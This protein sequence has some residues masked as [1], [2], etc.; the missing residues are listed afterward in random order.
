MRA[1]HCSTE[2]PGRVDLGAPT[3]DRMSHGAGYLA[4]FPLGHSHLGIPTWPTYDRM[5][6]ETGTLQPCGGRCRTLRCRRPIHSARECARNRESLPLVARNNA[7][8]QAYHHGGRKCPRGPW[9]A[10]WVCRLRVHKPQ[11]RSRR[12]PPGSG[13][14]RRQARGSAR[15]QRG[16]VHQRPC[17]NRPNVGAADW[18]GLAYVDAHSR[19]KSR[20]HAKR[21]GQRRLRCTCL[22]WIGSSQWHGSAAAC[23]RLQHVTSAAGLL[24]GGTR[25]QRSACGCNTLCCAAASHVCCAEADVTEGSSGGT[26][27][28]GAWT[29]LRCRCGPGHG[30]GP[31]ADV[32]AGAWTWSR[33]RCGRGHGHSPGETWVGP[34][35]R[36]RCRPV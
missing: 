20:A 27:V 10:R 15:T 23:S 16:P 11:D 3:Y 32:G 13:L 34:K 4:T 21:F 14:P 19:P 30:L 33:C 36:R 31:G 6:N 8:P 28:G 35:S 26:G 25:L 1:T 24:T 9:R 5:S 12:W 7:V 29:R 17:D 2:L 22:D 18:H